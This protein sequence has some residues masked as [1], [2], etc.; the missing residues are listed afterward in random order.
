MPN[1]VIA[2]MTE[3]ESRVVD[4]LSNLQRIARELGELM[5]E[6]VWE[7]IGIVEELKEQVL[8]YKEE[9]NEYR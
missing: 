4:G 1:E 3:E 7:T 8:K 9:S 2:S 5:Q 6:F